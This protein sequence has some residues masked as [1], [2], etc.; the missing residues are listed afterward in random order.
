MAAH[1][2]VPR[3]LT[4]AGEE[5]GTFFAPPQAD[6]E[7]VEDAE[8]EEREEGEEGVEASSAAPQALPQTRVAQPGVF[9]TPLPWNRSNRALVEGIH[10][11]RQRSK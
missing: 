2:V 5:K 11:Q 10:Q 4:R 9:L 1:G 8:D 7:S 6:S 3:P